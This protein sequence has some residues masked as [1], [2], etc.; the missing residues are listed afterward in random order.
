MSDQM[1]T[2][3]KSALEDMKAQDIVAIDVRGRTT[4][5]DFIVIAT[6][7]SNRHVKAVAEQ[8]ITQVK[9]EKYEVLSVE[10]KEAGEWVL[11]DCGDIVVHVMK[12]DV[13]AFYDLEQ[14]W[15][16]E[17]QALESQTL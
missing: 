2:L 15:R 1:T 13:R 9:K 12:D 11:V 8:V 6:G 3:I 5:T 17:I 16:T 10:G 7:T 4:I 14:L